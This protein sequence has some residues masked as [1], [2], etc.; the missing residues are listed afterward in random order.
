[1]ACDSCQRCPGVRSDKETDLRFLEIHIYAREHGESEGGRLSG[2]RLRL[3]DHIT[4]PVR[5]VSD[6]CHAGTLRET[7][8]FW[9]RRGNARS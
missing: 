1:M 2:S 3:S 9:R 4:R 7:N 8:G 5:A 6:R